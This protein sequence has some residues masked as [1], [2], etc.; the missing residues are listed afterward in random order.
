VADLQAAT[1]RWWAGQGQPVRALEHAAQSQDEALVTD[2]LRRLA[3][4]LISPGTTGHCAGRWRAWVR[5]PRR[6]DP[7]LAIASALTHLEAGA[8][9]AA[10]GDLR[11]ARQHWPADGRSTLLS[12][13]RGRLEQSRK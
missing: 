5:T 7:W 12:M 9:P 6:P 11:H 2:L 8:I 4:P 10:Q 3:V 1:A 13:P